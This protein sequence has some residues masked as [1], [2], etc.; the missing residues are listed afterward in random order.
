MT[1]PAR[2][3]ADAMLTDERRRRFVADGFLGVPG[4]FDRREVAAL[5]GEVDRLIGDGLLANV[6]TDGDGRT[7]SAHKANLQL[8]SAWRHSAL[9]RAVPFHP[10]VRALVGAL[11]GA[12]AFLYM[13]QIFLKPAGSGAPTNWHQDNFYFRLREPAYGLAVWL[14]VHDAT[15]A[16]GTIRFV[17]GSHRADLPHRRDPDSDY[18][19][20]CDPDEAAAVAVELPAGGVALFGYRTAHATGANATDRPRAGFA[21]HFAN[22]DHAATDGDHLD[23]AGRPVDYTPGTPGRPWINGPSASGGRREYGVD[24]ALHWH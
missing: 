20:R 23:R 19:H 2:T 1:A 5:Q 10:R 21:M 6:A 14:A 7:A 24:C 15:V 13:E 11:I 8:V 22:A 18:H 3:A 16:N 12:P 9:L 4:V 17:P